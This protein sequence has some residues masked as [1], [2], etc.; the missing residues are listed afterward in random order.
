M[1]LYYRI[2]YVT[3]MHPCRATFKY[4]QQWKFMLD[5]VQYSVLYT[6]ETSQ[7]G[8]ICSQ[9]LFRSFLFK[10]LKSFEFKVASSQ[11]NT[12][13]NILKFT[14]NKFNWWPRRSNSN[15][16]YQNAWFSTTK[17]NKH[18]LE[19]SKLRIFFLYW[20]VWLC[21]YSYSMMVSTMEVQQFLQGSFLAHAVKTRFSHSLRKYYQSDDLVTSL[22]GEISILRPVTLRM[23]V[24]SLY[25]NDQGLRCMH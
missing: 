7:F 5:N 14:K 22:F 3:V 18:F 6:G 23:Q 1:V 15:S 13:T 12:F 10:W 20:E 16:S 2:L 17:I 21:C 19:Y 24:L 11:K 8:F 4:Q 25:G 9:L